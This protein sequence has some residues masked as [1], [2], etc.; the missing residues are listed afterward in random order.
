MRF[1]AR[2]PIF[3]SARHVYG[4]E[5]LFR[6]DGDAISCPVASADASHDTLDISLFI[7]PGTLTEGRRAFIN[8]SRDLLVDDLATA[9]PPDLTVLE[10]L[11]NIEPDEEVVA[12]CARLKHAGYALA[13]DDF[14][15]S[16]D[17]SPL[18]RFADI[19][20]VDFQTTSPDEQ[21][22]IAE[23]YRRQGIAMLAEKVETQDDF[24]SARDAGYNLFQGYFFCNPT[25]I[26]AADIPALQVNYFRILQ[27][28]FR[29]ELDLFAL[30]AIIKTEPALCYRLL[31]YLNSAAYGVYPVTSI[32]HA[33]AL[34]GAR[35]LR[36]W[37]AIMSA[38]AIAGPNSGELVV[39]A[40]A[41][42]R[43]CESLAFT[44][45]AT[46]VDMFLLGLL[47]LVDAIL[48]QPLDRVLAQLP[49]QTELREALL[50]KYP[51]EQR[52]LRLAQACERGDWA[53][54]QS[55]CKSLVLDDNQVWYCYSGALTWAREL[56]EH[57]TTVANE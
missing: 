19:I 24:V 50:G 4:Y 25:T 3:D 23:R 21:R 20:K 57:T 55:V 18:V 51:A 38:I 29:P 28:A 26:S 52:M 32:R 53:T 31:R 22:A 54:L 47:S 5:L 11:E 43:F 12:A 1:V 42:A 17:R 10:I 39:T 33:L 49:L 9:L 37:V 27:S 6:Q 44:H 8:C 13:L 30:E 46:G 15:L 45:R 16:R 2:Q 7:G 56:H 40:L 48:D 41:R 14:D 34:L 36:K 35:D